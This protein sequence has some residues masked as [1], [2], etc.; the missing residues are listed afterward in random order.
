MGEYEVK[1]KKRK[2]TVKIL[3]FGIIILIFLPIGILYFSYSNFLNTPAS[4]SGTEVTY[5]VEKGFSTLNIIDG[6]YNRGLLTNKL[7]SKIYVK[8]NVKK[9]LKAGEYKFNSSMTPVAIFEELQRGARDLDLVRIT[10]PEGYNTKQMASLLY[11]KGLIKSEET[12][13][14]EAQN[15]E[16]EYDFVKNIPKDRPNRLEGYLF[17]D[18]YEF[19]TG[20]TEHD[21]IDKMLGRFEEIYESDISGKL[22]NRSLDELIIMASIVEREAKVEEER[23][24]IAAVFYNRLKINMQL[25]SCATIQ[26]I[27]GYNKEKLLNK[28]LEIESPYNTYKNSG[29]P[30]GPISN[31]GRNSIIAALEPADVDYLYFVLKQYNGDGSHNFASNYSDFLKYK[32]QLK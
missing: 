25:Q 10:F 22:G 21:I 2:K 19:R 13:I 26:Y 18:T 29:L 23:P 6:L 9:S 7:F 32:N 12:F 5:R 28:D 16:F 3:L 11:S 8:L 30:V 31:P 20:V 1:I 17:P 27:L 4:S 24:V 14:N 15:G